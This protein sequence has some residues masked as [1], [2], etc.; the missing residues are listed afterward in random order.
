[1]RITG[2]VFRSRALIAPRGQETRPTSDRVREALFSMLASAGLFADELG[3]RVLDLYA[4]S[5]A[6]GLEAVSRGA[7][8]AV[9]VESARPALAA[10]RENI[11]ALDVGAEVELVA[12]RVERALDT[13]EGPFDLV[14]VDPPYAD[15]KTRAFAETLAK[16]ARL[17][18]ASGV[19]VLEH[20]STDEPT[21]PAGLALDR[22]RRHGDTTLSLFHRAEVAHATDG[23]AGVADADDAPHE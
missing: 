4:G 3:P 22:R 14:L 1:M 20:A 5:G 23:A 17:L 2:G 7:R 10:I 9:L 21:P 18:A 19:L 12:T 16:A 13:V 6:L 15:V 11:R 8:S